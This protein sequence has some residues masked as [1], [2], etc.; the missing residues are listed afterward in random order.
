MKNSWYHYL[1]FSNIEDTKE[2]LERLRKMK[3]DM[4]FG[5]FKKIEQKTINRLD[6][7]FI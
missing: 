3:P 4:K 1:D 2:Y 5:I 7:E 6:E